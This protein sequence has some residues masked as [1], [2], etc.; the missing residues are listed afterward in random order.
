MRARWKSI[1]LTAVLAAL[2]GELHRQQRP[3]RLAVW[4]P[5]LG[6]HANTQ[7]ADLERCLAQDD[8]TGG[9]WSGPASR[10][11]VEARP[12]RS[13]PGSGRDRRP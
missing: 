13:S 9:P 5:R 12:A 8:W 2:A 1:V 11:V 4:R 3:R 6:W 7:R 10:L